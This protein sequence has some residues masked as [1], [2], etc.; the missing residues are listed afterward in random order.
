MLDNFSV[1]PITEALEII[2]GKYETEASGG[3]DLKISNMQPQE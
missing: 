2:D 1:E 3:I